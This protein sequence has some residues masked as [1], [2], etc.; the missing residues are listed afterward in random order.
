MVVTKAFV[1]PPR[2]GITGKTGNWKISLPPQY[3]GNFLINNERKNL[4]RNDYRS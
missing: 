1:S 2:E 4:Q 3:A